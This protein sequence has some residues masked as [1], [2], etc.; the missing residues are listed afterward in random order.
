MSKKVY[1]VF[2][3]ENIHMIVLLMNTYKVSR[4]VVIDH[5][6]PV[7]IVTSQDL[8]PAS[9]LLLDKTANTKM[10][11]NINNQRFIPSRLSSMFL[12]EDIMTRSPLTVSYN[13]NLSDAARIMVRNRIS[14]LPVVNNKGLLSGII[15]KTDIVK[16]M[17]KEFLIT[18]KK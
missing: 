17:Y 14:G 16:T 2:P 9:S 12:A 1:T 11:K 18:S 4:I 6:K 10:V 13:A 15:T 3:D 5:N 7:G 8:L